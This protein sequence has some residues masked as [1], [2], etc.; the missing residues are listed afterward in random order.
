MNEML[1][2][3]GEASGWIIPEERLAEIAAIYKGTSDDTKPLREL[4]LATA[5]PT[6]IFTAE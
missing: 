4:D 3:L 2:K 6:S 5:S 1:K